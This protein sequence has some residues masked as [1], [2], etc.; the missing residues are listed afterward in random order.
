MAP[1]C[2]ALKDGALKE[3]FKDCLRR[4]SAT[5]YVERIPFS[6]RA[7]HSVRAALTLEATAPMAGSRHRFGR[8]GAPGNA[9]LPGTPPSTPIGKPAS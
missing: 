1:G 2:D 7:R 8:S 9:P 3:Q 4:R 5:G 6:G